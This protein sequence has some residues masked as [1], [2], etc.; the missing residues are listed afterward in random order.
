MHSFAQL[1]SGDDSVNRT[2]I[3]R[4]MAALAAVLIF[5]TCGFM[6]IQDQWGFWKSIYFTLITITTVGYGDYG[7]SPAGQQFTAVLLVGGIATAT[8]AFG[9]LMQSIVA[10]QLNWRARMQKEIDQLR[11]HHI[12]CGFGRVGCLVCG[13]LD[14]ESIPFVVI[15]KD[16]E[17][18]KQA[19]ERGYYAIHG[20]GSDD[21][22]L[23]HAGVDR[24]RSVVTAVDS[25]SENILITLSAR[26]LNPK[27]QIIS[28]ADGE[29]VS[30]KI[31]RAGASH[32]VSPAHKGGNDMA[33]LIIN[34]HL[35]DF[36]Q[37][38]NG[39]DCGYKLGEVRIEEGSSLVGRTPS[40]VG[41][42]EPS[43]VFVAIKHSDGSTQIRPS[44]DQAF[45][46]NDILIFAGDYDAIDRMIHA[47]KRNGRKPHTASL[48]P[49]G[50]HVGADVAV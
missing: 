48:A 22:L 32:V 18:F 21:E 1:D 42:Q 15:E 12:I 33:E 4:A 40:E 45:Q 35:S 20:A 34:P 7:L 9:Q 8:Y 30:D 46:S 29:G 47:A 17:R 13:R 28:R 26:E 41:D 3:L 50:V 39:T 14:K 23:I 37:G 2:R 5:G 43:L 11:D 6:I 24:A 16:N 25:D 44:V 38:S 49:A 27:V 10:Y 31:K 19:R 36:L